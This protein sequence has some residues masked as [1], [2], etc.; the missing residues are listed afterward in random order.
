[1]YDDLIYKIAVILGTVG[2][3]AFLVIEDKACSYLAE[4]QQQMIES[5]VSGLTGSEGLIIDQIDF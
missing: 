3:L 2:V 4:Q 5:F 1:M